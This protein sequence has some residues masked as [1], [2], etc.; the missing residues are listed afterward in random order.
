MRLLEELNEQVVDRCIVCGGDRAERVRRTVLATVGGAYAELELVV[1]YC[2][3]DSA[4]GEAKAMELIGDLTAP[5]V[6][7]DLRRRGIGLLDLGIPE[8][9]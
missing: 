6:V 1:E 2:A 8:E 3:D 7:A 9:A 4:C 5:F